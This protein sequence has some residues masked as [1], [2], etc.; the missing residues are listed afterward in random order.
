MEVDFEQNSRVGVHEAEKS[1]IPHECTQSTMNRLALQ[2]LAVRCLPAVRVAHKRIPV[3]AARRSYSSPVSSI[4]L[5]NKTI[6]NR[7][8]LYVTD[9]LTPGSI[10]FLPHGARIFN[11]LIEF[12]RVQQ[13]LYG[14]EEVV[15]P[16][17]Y[18]NDLWITSGHYQHY[19]QDMFQVTGE[20]HHEHETP[21][22]SQYGLKPMNCPGH[23][24]MFSKHDHSF[25]DLPVRFADFSPL[26]RN[27]SSGALSGLTRVRKF[28]QDDGHIFCEPSQIK[29]EIE[30]CL[31][32]IETSYCVFGLNE[33]RLSLS[34]RPE[35]YVGTLDV[36]EK[37][38]ENLKQALDNSG[39]AWHINEGD[40]AFYGPK[41]DIL[42]KDNTGKEHQTA[43][44]QLDFQ[45]PKNFDLKYT[46]SS[47]D[48][49]AAESTPVLIHRAVFGSLE[50][51]MAILMDHYEG[52]WPFWLNP[53]QAAIIP[54]A[55]RHREYASKIYSQ[56][57]GKNDFKTTN[58]DGKSFPVAVQPG[59]LHSRYFNADLLASDETVGARTRRAIS[60]GY[61]YILMVG[62]RE[63]ENG[64][65]SVRPR[66]DRKT[67][68]I[69]VEEAISRFS[70]LEDNYE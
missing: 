44:I 54:V 4:A 40:G 17:I 47:V 43:T 32:L 24:V 38:E 8:K 2:R 9:Q 22:D 49:E 3:V 56:L 15:T 26:H 30:A 42:V 14:F 7:Q 61:S 67:Q 57:S 25:R 37:A 16:L 52:A 55:E 5:D 69:S 34:T 36:W 46:G 60:D 45:L 23:C 53:K 41:I 66:S 33:Y 10:F 27:E 51:F 59:K 64:T 39:K 50:R 11:R 18:K 21:E 20:H 31:A 68:E 58:A 48:P 29:S 12:M 6:A 28:H 35:G 13:R 62:D 63:V 70:N 19:K 65:V 1:G